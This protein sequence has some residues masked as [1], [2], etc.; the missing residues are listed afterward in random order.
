MG[1]IQT[2]KLTLQNV[3]YQYFYLYYT[4]KPK[5]KFILSSNFMKNKDSNTKMDFVELF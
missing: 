2:Y 4:N 3:S 1:F 5:F